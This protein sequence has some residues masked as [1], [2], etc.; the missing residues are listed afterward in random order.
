M[1]SLNLWV[2]LTFAA[3]AAHATVI[4]PGGAV[5]PNGVVSAVGTSSAVLLTESGNYQFSAIPPDISASYVETAYADTT[6]P[7]GSDDT[8]LVLQITVGA[9]TA[10]IERATLGYFGDFKTSVSYVSSSSAAPTGATRDTSGAVIGYNFV[11][12]TPGDTETLVVY[13]SAKGAEPGGA[14]SIQNG[15]A[16]DAPGISVV[17][18]PAAMGGLSGGL[19]MCSAWWLAGKRR[20]AR[21][22]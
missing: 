11:G 19:A 14:L 13:T 3:V 20:R 18:E 17:P 22:S 6:N 1:K 10:T 15:T 2:G 9:G 7:F 5:M 16:G 12:L 8:T 4:N 21:K